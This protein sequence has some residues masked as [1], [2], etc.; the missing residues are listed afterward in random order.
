MAN[1]EDALKIETQASSAK[2][3]TFAFSISSILIQLVLSCSLFYV[4][5]MIEG[6]QIVDSLGLFNAKVPANTSSF[7]ENI[8]ELSSFNLIDL[9][10]FRESLMYMP[11]SDAFSLTF[12][13]EGYE[14]I[15]VVSLLEAQFF[16]I[17][18]LGMIILVDLILLALSYKW[19]SI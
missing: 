17:I 15:Y 2:G 8:S 16:Y 7:L 10:S 19:P 11:E 13:S 9:S 1:E 14:S 4:W 12:Q 6:L 5:G 3:S 18:I